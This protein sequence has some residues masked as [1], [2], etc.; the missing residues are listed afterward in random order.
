M[1]TQH[2][3]PLSQLLLPSLQQIPASICTKVLV[4][5]SASR[6]LAQKQRLSAADRK[7]KYIVNSVTTAAEHIDTDAA[8]ELIKQLMLMSV[9]GTSACSAYFWLQRFRSLL[10][11]NVIVCRAEIILTKFR[12]R[13][14]H[15]R[16]SRYRSRPSPRAWYV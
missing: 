5:V 9:K 16:R 12:G 13:T 1:L 4:Q 11:L 2:A 15:P 8:C 14:A 10:R 3:Q 6:A 7:R